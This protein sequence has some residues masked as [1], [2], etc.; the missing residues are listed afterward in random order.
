MTDL[1]DHQIAVRPLAPSEVVDRQIQAYNARDIAAVCDLYALDAV[2]IRLHDGT[3]LC[4][5][6]DAVRS[7]YA[8][9][10]A[11]HAGAHCQLQAR[12]A[13]GNFVIDQERVTGTARGVLEGVAIYEVLHQRIQT[14]HFLDRF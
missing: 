14:V 13:I 9:F 3:E 6:R 5:G 2:L 10:F 11:D 7:R 1:S 8:R 4:R 12:I